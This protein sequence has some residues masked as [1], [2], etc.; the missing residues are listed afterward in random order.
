MHFVLWTKGS[1]QSPHFD[2]SE[3]SGE[4]SPN[5]SSRFPNHK[6]VILQILHH[7]SVSWKTTPLYFLIKKIYTLVTRS[8]I[9]CKFLRLLSAQ[10]KVSQIAHV[11]F[12]TT[13]QFLF[14]FFYIFCKFLAHAFSTLGKNIPSNSQF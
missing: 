9:K 5:S 6:S 4:N 7:S 10:V 12:K 14:K 13:S 2:T 3:F 1:Y 8:P 11:T